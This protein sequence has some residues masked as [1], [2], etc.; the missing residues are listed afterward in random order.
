MLLFCR[1]KKS[2]VGIINDRRESEAA[3]NELHMLNIVSR[4][5]LIIQSALQ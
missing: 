2:S 3:D 4:E 1:T 5:I